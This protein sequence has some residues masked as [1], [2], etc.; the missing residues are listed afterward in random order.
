M[1]GARVSPVEVG[2]NPEEDL[3]MCNRDTM[4][5]LWILFT[6]VGRKTAAR[7]TVNPV[8]ETI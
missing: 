8:K 3:R 2:P 7:L 4:D 5:A 6:L 1:N